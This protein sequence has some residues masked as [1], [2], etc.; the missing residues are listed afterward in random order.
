MILFL[1]LSRS[2]HYPVGPELNAIG[3]P[4]FILAEFSLPRPASYPV[5]ILQ[6]QKVVDRRVI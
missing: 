3:L 4:L 2:D 1:L 6:D 5:L